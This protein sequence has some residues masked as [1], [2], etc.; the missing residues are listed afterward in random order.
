MLNKIYILLFD[1]FLVD[2][3]EFSFAL[4]VGVFY[5]MLSRLAFKVSPSFIW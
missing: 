4:C 2:Y 5:K 1:C 3:P